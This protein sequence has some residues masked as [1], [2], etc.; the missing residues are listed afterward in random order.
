MRDAMQAFG[1]ER[2]LFGSAWPLSLPAFTWK[3]VL[4]YFTQ[5]HSALPPGE[6]WKMIGLNAARV[7]RLASEDA[8]RAS[9]A[10]E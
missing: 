8:I 6:R 1:F 5:T 7:Y 10:A 2:V 9:E 4:A 3:Q